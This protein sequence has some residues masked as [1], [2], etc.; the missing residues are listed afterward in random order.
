[1]FTIKGPIFVGEVSRA[2]PDVIRKA[3]FGYF[4]ITAAHYKKPPELGLQF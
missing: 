2:V 3:A 4:L 1:M